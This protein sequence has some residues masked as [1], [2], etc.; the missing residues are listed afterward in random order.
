MWI[1]S[2]YSTLPSVGWLS[3]LLLLLLLLLLYQG[4]AKRSLA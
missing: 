1:C 2:Q 4:E 3:L